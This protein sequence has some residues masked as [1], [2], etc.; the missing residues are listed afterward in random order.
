MKRTVGVLAL[1]LGLVL[2]LPAVAI[3]SDDAFFPEQWALEVIGAETAWS[4]G[5]GSGMVIA[6]VDTG[7]D[8]NHPDLA[9]KLVSGASF[10]GGSAQ[11]NNG[12]GTHLAGVA[13]AG[14]GNGEGIAG[15]A[16]DARIMPVKVLNE[17]GIGN[18]S[19]VA[20]GI[21]YAVDNGADVIN[22]SLG[23]QTS[24]QAALLTNALQYAW[25]RGVIPVIAAGNSA[26]NSRFTDE[27]VVVVT[28]TTSS[29]SKASYATGVSGAQWGMAAPGGDG[30]PNSSSDQA[31]CDTS[32][33]IVSTYIDD[34]YACL[35]G[36]SMAV[37]HVAGAAAVL[38]GMGLTPQQTV[39]QL[40]ATADDLG[41][42]GRD[43]LFGAGRLNLA[44]AVQAGVPT[45]T[46]EAPTTTTTEAP[47]VI[48]VAPTTVP[49]TTTTVP[50]TTTTETPTTT[51]PSPTVSLPP[52]TAVPVE[53]PGDQ[54]VAL[55]PDDGDD[56][57]RYVAAV[58]A[59]L[60]LAGVA[61]ATWQVRRRL[62][63]S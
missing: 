39:D 36:T 6:I 9:G 48:T 27:P 1:A 53:P 21:E 34:S 44:R 8:L 32:T 49:P 14:T 10:V 31:A 59:G 55:L 11:D 13:A 28:A 2:A 26:G 4:Q 45:T 22:L 37:P 19:D 60:L 18:E 15:V 25:D 47:A 5:T 57:A 29:D 58:P 42:A 3:A 35:V 56:N 16:P 12:H 38:R 41:P 62:S 50:P 61:S 30:N 24:G 54:V 63:P 20:A 17:R 23:E 51:V 33:A 7:V 40:L 43:S 46:T 52:T